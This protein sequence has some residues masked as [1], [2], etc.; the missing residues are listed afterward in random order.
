M[1]YI[2]RIAKKKR[3]FAKICL[4]SFRSIIPIITFYLQG[5]FSLARAHFEVIFYSVDLQYCKY[6]LLFVV[7]DGRSFTLKIFHSRNTSRQK[8]SVCLCIVFINCTTSL[9]SSIERACAG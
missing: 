6:T 3:I 1:T 5:R 2:T 7:E 9:M 8:N 4:L